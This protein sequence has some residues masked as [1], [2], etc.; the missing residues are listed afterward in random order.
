MRQSKGLESLGKD[1]KQSKQKEIIEIQEEQS[2]DI[3]A[4]SLK[5]KSAE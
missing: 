4:E 3:S 5:R 1:S 2:E